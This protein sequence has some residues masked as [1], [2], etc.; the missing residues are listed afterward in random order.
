ME[1]LNT[2]KYRFKNAGIVEQLIYVNLAIY[3]LVFITNIFQPNNNFIIEWFSLPA[4]FD[5][6]LSKP[7]T[8]IT[9]GFLHAGF[10]HIL[11]NLFALFY[12]GHFFKQY[13][14]AKQLLNFYLLGTVFGG[15]I[16]MA[17]YH[18]FPALQE[19]VDT[20]ILLGASAGISAIFIGI[21]TYIPSYELKIPLIGFVKLWKLAG[22]WVAL[23]VLQIPAGNLGGHLAHIGGALFGFLYVLKA[24]NKEIIVFNTLR[25]TVSK[26]FE[27]K[28]KPL[29]TV[30]KSGKKPTKTTFKKTQKSKNQQKI[31]TIL[32]KISTSGYDTL[33][34]TEKD[35]LFKQGK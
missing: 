1:T 9:Y 29:K 27:K 19:V 10:I 26:Y 33:T 32:D 8:I 30:Y 34:Q 24:S 13:F 4:N 6:F 7:W 22:I 17:S 18:F 3:I 25:K 2:L 15:V 20:S 31:D 16:F 21:A 14:T 28:E 5:E 12:I 11:S 23:D 35:F